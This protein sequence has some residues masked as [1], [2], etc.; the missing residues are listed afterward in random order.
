MSQLLLNSTVKDTRDFK[1]QPQGLVGLS[2]LFPIAGLGF[3]INTVVSVAASLY[4][5]GMLRQNHVYYCV[6]STLLG[7]VITLFINVFRTSSVVIA[8]QNNQLAIEASKK[9]SSS[10]CEV[11]FENRF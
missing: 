8:I 3:V 1:C 4:R 2:L 6:Q 10:Y 11:S 5:K 9:V 7:N